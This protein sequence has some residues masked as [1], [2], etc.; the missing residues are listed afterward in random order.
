MRD[1]DRSETG[2]PLALLGSA[3]SDVRAQ[4]RCDVQ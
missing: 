4:T 2:S 1:F 3:P